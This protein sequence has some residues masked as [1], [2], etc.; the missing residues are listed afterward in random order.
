MVSIPQADRDADIMANMKRRAL[1]DIL[2]RSRDDEHAVLAHVELLEP[3]V[4]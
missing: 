1:A 2:E 4:C 3:R